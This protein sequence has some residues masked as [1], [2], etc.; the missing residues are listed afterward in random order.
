MVCGLRNRKVSGGTQA[1]SSLHPKEKINMLV[2]VYWMTWGVVGL[3]ALL[4]FAAGSFTMLAG[5][6][7]GFIAFGM[8]FMGMMG[9]LPV[10]VSHP[11]PPKQE[12]APTQAL[13]PIRETP[14]NAFGIWKS[15]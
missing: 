1:A 4:L 10:M 8:T 12:K 3:A 13:Q 15:A 6:V 11:A 7:F 2:K 14:A 9:V 5:V